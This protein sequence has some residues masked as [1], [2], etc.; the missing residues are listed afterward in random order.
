MAELAKILGQNFGASASG[1][2]VASDTCAPSD[3]QLPATGSAD[4]TRHKEAAQSDQTPG[5]DFMNLLR[6]KGFQR[7]FIS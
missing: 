7:I 6:P 1:A 2:T 5:V 3:R 4:D